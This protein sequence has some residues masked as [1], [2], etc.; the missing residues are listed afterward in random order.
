MKTLTG[1]FLLMA[2]LAFADFPPEASDVPFRQV[3]VTA[4]AGSLGAIGATPPS[5]TPSLGV[6]VM[7]SV[8]GAAVRV[9]FDGQEPTAST[10]HLIPNGSFMV[11]PLATAR[12]AR[13]IRAGDT[14]AV[15][16]IT[17]GAL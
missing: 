16:A 15:I 7:L 10:G 8:H 5:Q 4:A 13:F 14:D 2:R 12:K 17:E 1:L 11:W 6:V 3:A 9:R